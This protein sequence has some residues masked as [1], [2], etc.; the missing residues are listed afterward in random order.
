M[1][2]IFQTNWTPAIETN[3][4]QREDGEHIKRFC[5]RFRENADALSRRFHD[6][7]LSPQDTV[8]YWT[9]YVLEHDGA[10]H[11]KSHATSVELYEYYSLDLFA[12]AIA[13]VVSLLYFVYSIISLIKIWND[14]L[15]ATFWNGA[16]DRCE[17]DCYVRFLHIT[18]YLEKYWFHLYF[19][20]KFILIL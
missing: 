6:R 10:H 15:Q 5:C 14:A 12:T 7:P 2:K 1:V 3:F 4:C 8:A 17:N 13:I 11:L 18:R 19:Y 9:N 20:F 16:E